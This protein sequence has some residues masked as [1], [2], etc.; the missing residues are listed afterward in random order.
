LWGYKCYWCQKPK[1]YYDV[2]ID[3]II[4]QTVKDE[5]L[6][7]LAAQFGLDTGFDIHDP[8]NLAPICSSCNGPGGKGDMDLGDVPIVLTRLRKAEKLRSPSSRGCRPLP[9]LGRLP[10]H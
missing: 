8:R 10:R 1:D 2:A 7:E 3:H 4:P 6:E 5:R 9:M